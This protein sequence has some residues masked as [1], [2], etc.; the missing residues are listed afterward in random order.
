MVAPAH[1]WCFSSRRKFLDRHANIPFKTLSLVHQV[2]IHQTTLQV[3]YIIFSPH[4]VYCRFGVLSGNIDIL[5][6]TNQSC[7][8]PENLW[9]R[10]YVQLVN[11]GGRHHE[12]ALDWPCR[13]CGRLPSAS[14][15]KGNTNH[16]RWGNRRMRWGSNTSCK[17][18]YTSLDSSA[19]WDSLMWTYQ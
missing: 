8:S 11:D 1:N 3:F 17:S 4:F 7:R 10:S 2:Q 13:A 9:L 12:S 18:T 19:T 15:W 14:S 5:E 6:F 16:L